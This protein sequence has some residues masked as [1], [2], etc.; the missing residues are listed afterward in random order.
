MH[1]RQSALTS[2]PGAGSMSSFLS[3]TALGTR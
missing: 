3:I 2:L 1:S